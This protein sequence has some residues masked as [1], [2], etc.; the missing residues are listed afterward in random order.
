MNFL[1]NARTHP[2]GHIPIN[3][4]NFVA[5]LIFAHFFEIHPASLEDAVVIAG[6]GGLDEALCLD[7]ECAD[8]FENFR[9]R[10]PRGSVFSSGA[11]KRSFRRIENMHGT[12]NPAKIRS[13]IVSLV[14]VS[15]SAS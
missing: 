3:R 4:A 5:G 1:T 10:L 7:F 13:M 15:A 8:F 2:R 9:W 11:S 14:I 6:E 12:G